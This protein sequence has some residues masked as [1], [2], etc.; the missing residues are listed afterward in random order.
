MI[1]ELR[2][3]RCVTGRLPA[4]LKRFETTTLTLWKKHGIRQAGFWTTLIGESNNDLTY[5]LV[6]DSL[7]EREQKWNAFASDPEW[8]AKRA[9]SERDGPIVETLSNQILA[10][11]AFS[12]VK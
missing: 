5:L 3:Y 2:V 10:P 6:W 4:L 9:E 8:L 11:T 1:Y 7:A 12:A